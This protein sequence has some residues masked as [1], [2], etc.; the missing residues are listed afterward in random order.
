MRA[1]HKIEAGCKTQ[2][3]ITKPFEDLGELR[4]RIEFSIQPYSQPLGYLA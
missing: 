2:T 3:P 4:A 1:E